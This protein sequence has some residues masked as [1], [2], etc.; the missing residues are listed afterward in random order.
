MTKTDSFY[1]FLTKKQYIYEELTKKFGF[2]VVNYWGSNKS[3]LYSFLS[4]EFS[5]S[6]D[7]DA[8]CPLGWDR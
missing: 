8:F 7:K 2:G 1:T 4:L 6:G 5:I 3:S